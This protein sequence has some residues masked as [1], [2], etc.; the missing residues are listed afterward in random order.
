MGCVARHIG[1]R[2]AVHVD[3]DRAQFMR[4]QAGAQIHRA[5]ARSGPACSI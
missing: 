5:A 2:H 4:D 3:A 1:Q